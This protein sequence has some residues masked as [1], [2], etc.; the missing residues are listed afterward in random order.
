MLLVLFAGGSYFQWFPLRG[1]TSDNWEE[2][3]LIGKVLD[4]FW[5]L[6]LPLAASMISAFTFSTLLTKNSFLDEI[7]KQYVVTARSKGQLLLLAYS[8]AVR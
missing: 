4:Y 8:S 2:L 5:H 6:A 1:L 3:S 7:S